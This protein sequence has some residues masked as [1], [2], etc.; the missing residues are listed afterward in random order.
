MSSGASMSGVSPLDG[1][2]RRLVGAVDAVEAAVAQCLEQ[3]R[4]GRDRAV[5][6]ALL[7][8]DR[9]RL[10]QDLDSSNTRAATLANVNRAVGR[11][12]DQAID[13]IRSVVAAHER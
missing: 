1:A 8:E 2:I 10:A 4:T 6:I 5:E 13:T 11:R 3:S 7:E 12:L 9:A